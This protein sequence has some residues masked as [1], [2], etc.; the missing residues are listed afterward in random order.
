MSLG[1][2]LGSIPMRNAAV[3]AKMSFR[4][5]CPKTMLEKSTKIES[6]KREIMEGTPNYVLSSINDIR[7]RN[8]FL[9]KFRI[10]GR[11]AEITT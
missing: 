2:L 10:I 1:R 4:P 11:N 5:K 6:S 8:N 9:R 3:S 7:T